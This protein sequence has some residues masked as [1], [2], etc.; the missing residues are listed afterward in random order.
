M[1]SLVTFLLSNGTLL[2]LS[3]PLWHHF[4]TIWAPFWCYFQDACDF[5]K[6]AF[7]V[8]ET[9]LFDIPG[10]P[11]SDFFDV[12]CVA[13]FFLYFFSEFSS[14]VN[15]LW[16]QSGTHVSQTCSKRASEGSLWQS[17]GAP[18]SIQGG[19]KSKG[20]R[21]RANTVSKDIVLRPRLSEKVT[22]SNHVQ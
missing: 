16:T 5:W 4:W 2:T 19:T 10:G 7:R 15:L 17:K 6:H 3:G 11:E 21:K 13:L 12:I 20:L 9:L 1:A 22:H 18:K 8:H 14:V